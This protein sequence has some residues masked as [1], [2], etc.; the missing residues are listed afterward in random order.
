MA[1]N[2]DKLFG[3]TRDALGEPTA[4]FVDFFDQLGRQD[5]RVLDVGCGQGRDA[6]FVARKGHR[7]VGVDISQN[8]I[9]D[10]RNVAAQESLPIEGVVAD[11]ASYEPVGFFDIVLIDRTLHMLA[12]QERLTVLGRLLD[13]VEK[14]GWVLIAD[15]TSNIE[16]F[17]S[18]LSAHPACWHTALSHG[19]KLFL[20]RT[21]R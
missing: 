11:I 6:I 14:Q 9:R 21:E 12:R 19:G 1:Y 4:V 3:E 18:V 10:L 17:K 2:Y 20:C 16:D 8:G 5:V 13:H 7:V 15:E